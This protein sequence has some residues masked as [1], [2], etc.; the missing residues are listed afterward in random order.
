MTPG[1]VR[2]ISIG[3]R[4][5]LAHRGGDQGVLAFGYA[6]QGSASEGPEAK[7][8]R[9]RGDLR[10]KQRR[11]LLRQPRRYDRRRGP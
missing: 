7:G 4:E 1:L 6:G 10:S 3:L 8:Q 5:R 9:C 2:R 11:Q